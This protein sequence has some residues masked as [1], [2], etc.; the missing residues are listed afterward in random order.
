MATFKYF[1]LILV[2]SLSL[3]ASSQKRIETKSINEKQEDLKNTLELA[4]DWQIANFKAGTGHDRGLD[5]WTN[6]TLYIGM[7]D[8]ATITNDKKYVD[9]L[10]KC[11]EQNQW[12]VATQY[13]YHADAICVG[14]FYIRMYNKLHETKIIKS[15]KERADWI[16]NNPPAAAEN[17]RKWSWSDALFMAPPFYAQLTV[18]TGDSKYFKFMDQEFKTTYQLLY[19]K[20][21]CLFYRDKSYFSK[22]EANGTKVFWGRGNAWV[23]AG[24]VNI[25]KN[26]PKDSEFR[27][28]YSNLY[29]EMIKRIVTL[30]NEDGF[31][32]AS[33]LD[34]QSYPAP[35]SSA[36]ALIT[37]ALAYGINE[38][39]LDYDLYG[40]KLIKSWTGLVSAVNMDG[41]LGWVQPIG[42]DPKKVT[43]EMTDVFGVGAFLMAGVEVYKLTNKYKITESLPSHSH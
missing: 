30:Q 39:L 31:W 8:L 32:H 38:G 5:A 1:S 9:W 34:P 16:I 23:L 15:V 28:F 10:Y 6:A 7:F 35:E 4:A 33:L 14:Q 37:Y 43:S 22:R 18:L 20:E 29:L 12:K 21:E 19:D 40:N 41:K 26:L 25:L 42:A 13:M 11:G 3:N 24:L 2:L 17:Y 27:P 36:T